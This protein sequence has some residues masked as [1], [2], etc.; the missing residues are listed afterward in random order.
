M[1]KHRIGR[2]FLQYYLSL[3]ISAAAAMPEIEISEL[4][5]PTPIVRQ[6]P[7]R[8]NDGWDERELIREGNVEWVITRDRGPGVSST[9]VWN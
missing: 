6:L 3:R 5:F 7:A 4:Q 9:F 1:T 8:T 2:L